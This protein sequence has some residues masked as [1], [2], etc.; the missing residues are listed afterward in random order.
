MYR[1][2]LA[3]VFAL[4]VLAFGV[5]SSAERAQAPAPVPVP[6]PAPVPPP[7]P[8]PASPGAQTPP[9]RQPAEL[10]EAPGK[11][12][13]VNLCSGCHEAESYILME[14]RSD[15]GWTDIVT[16]MRG[17]GLKVTSDELDTLMEYLTANYGCAVRQET[18]FCAPADAPVPSHTSTTSSEP[19]PA[20][21]HQ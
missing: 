8:T 16:E 13:V 18:G 7:A 10:K 19:Q 5:S 21:P 11:D 4:F 15:E 2:S 20:A 17:L 1:A 12:V 3:A 9:A 6:T 14:R